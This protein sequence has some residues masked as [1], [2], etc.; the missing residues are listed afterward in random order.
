M[1]FILLF[2]ISGLEGPLLCQG[3]FPERRAV[4]CTFFSWIKNDYFHKIWSY[5]VDEVIKLL[6][7]FPTS[8][9]TFYNKVRLLV[10]KKYTV[11]DKIFYLKSKFSSS[12]IKLNYFSIWS[13]IVGLIKVR[14]AIHYETFHI[15]LHQK[16]S[17]G[18]ANT[19]Q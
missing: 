6:T 18:T 10:Y 19:S 13:N 8:F 12:E 5:N 14:L 1:F 4:R 3:T 17:F 9:N 7:F 2:L 16:L 11:I 15:L